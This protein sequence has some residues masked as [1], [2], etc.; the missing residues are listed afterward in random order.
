MTLHTVPEAS[1]I[2]GC[3]MKVHSAIGPGALESVYAECLAHESQSASL[4]FKRQV[5]LP[6][7]YEGIQ[8]DR[9][10]VADLIVN[11]AVVVEVKAIDRIL[12]VHIAQV[13]TYLRLSGVRKGLLINFRVK[14]L[15]DGIRSVISG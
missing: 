10:Y 12:P 2:I 8:L 14:R 15:K 11:N 5:A 7:R 3:A 4:P 9:A 6:L 13:A 1:I